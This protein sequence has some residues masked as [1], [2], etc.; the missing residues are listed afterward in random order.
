MEVRVYVGC[1][2]YYFFFLLH[3]PQQHHSSST[4]HHHRHSIAHFNISFYRTVLSMLFEVASEGRTGLSSPS[5]IFQETGFAQSEIEN[6]IKHLK[7]S[8]RNN[9]LRM[10]NLARPSSIIIHTTVFC[11]PLSQ[12]TSLLSYQF[13]ILSIYKCHRTKRNSRR[14][15]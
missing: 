12:Q 4:N 5:I 10:L 8:F 7:S 1:I 11:I 2:I 15:S 13:Q 9:S 14:R 3:H 6:L